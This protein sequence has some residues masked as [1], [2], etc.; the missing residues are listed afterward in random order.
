[1]QALGSTS[2]S[3]QTE[4][5]QQTGAVGACVQPQGMLVSPPST[6]SPAWL[7]VTSAAGSLGPLPQQPTR[8]PGTVALKCG[9]QHSS[10][11]FTWELVRNVNFRVHF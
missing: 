11:G 7:T 9:S 8:A 3:F 4:L 1:M 5:L 6:P 10:P 2:T